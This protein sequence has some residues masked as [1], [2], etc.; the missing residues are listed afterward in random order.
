VRIELASRSPENVGVAMNEEDRVR[1]NTAGSVN[2]E[3]DEQILEKVKSHA[4]TNRNE[5]SYR[6]K[7]LDREWDIERILELNA[8][9][10]A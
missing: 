8:S 1:K 6:I 7:E 5:I 9:A 10:I 3:I 4:G 2:R